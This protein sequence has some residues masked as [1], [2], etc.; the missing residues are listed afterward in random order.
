MAISITENELLDALAA[1]VGDKGPEE[2]QTQEEIARTT[3]INVK[4]VR[5]AMK[6]LQSQGRL[7]VHRVMR[8][9]LDGVLVPVTAYTIKPV[10]AS[11]HGIACSA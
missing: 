8:A 10:V 1:A 3:N 2:A 4:R 5:L 11:L 6:E 7:V 9:R